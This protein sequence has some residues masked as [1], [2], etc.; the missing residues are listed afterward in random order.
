MPRTKD[1]QQGS[2]QDR[3]NEDVECSA[4]DQTRVVLRILVQI[5]A[6]GA[7][8]LGLHDLARR[9]PYVRL[10]ATTADSPNDRAVIANQHLRGLK[11]RSRSPNIH[12]GSHRAAAPFLTKLND[13]LVDVH[14]F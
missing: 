3:F 4:A 5:E 13:L 10:N 2:R 9:S 1:V 14:L 11:R 12:D 6:E 7:R 8:L